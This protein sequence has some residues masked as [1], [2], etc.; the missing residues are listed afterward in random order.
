MIILAIIL[1]VISLWLFLMGI[2]KWRESDGYEGGGWLVAGGIVGVIWFIV[3]LMTFR[4]NTGTNNLTGYIYS[5]KTSFGYTTGH[6]RFSEQAGMDAQPS[7]CVKADSE[8]GKQIT[9]L[10]GSGK[11]V[12]VTEPAYFYFTNNPFA[13]GTT[14]MKVEV[15]K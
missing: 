14:N 6:I 3:F 10:A 7:F 2:A 12:V 11:K 5:S 13:C 4:L 15:V 1:G 8:A 9:E